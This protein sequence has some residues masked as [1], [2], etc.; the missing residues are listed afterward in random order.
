[1]NLDSS[2]SQNNNAFHESLIH[3]SGDPSPVKVGRFMHNDDCTQ[4]V[5][6][7]QQTSTMGP[8][9]ANQ[10]EASEKGNKQTLSISTPVH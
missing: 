10:G 6:G 1:M 8:A 9:K 4:S 3:D 7:S 2:K 5:P